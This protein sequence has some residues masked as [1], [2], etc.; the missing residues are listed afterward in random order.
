MSQ[1]SER[2]EKKKVNFV[3]AFCSF[4]V[5]HLFVS[6]GLGIMV[7][8]QL[9]CLGTPQH[10]KSRF[11]QG[12]QL[13]LTLKND[14]LETRV[15]IETDLTIMFDYRLLDLNHEKVTY[16]LNVNSFFHNF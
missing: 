4:F 15:Q 7:E 8:G 14:S 5:L 11:G 2:K 13:D 12:Y 10:I 9:K 3:F 6:I 16:E 1:F